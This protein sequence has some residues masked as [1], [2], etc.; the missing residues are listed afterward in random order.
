[1][2]VWIMKICFFLCSISTMVNGSTFLEFYNKITF[3]LKACVV[4]IISCVWTMEQLK[5]K[6]KKGY[7]SPE[8]SLKYVKSHHL[9]RYTVYMTKQ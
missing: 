1:M 7:L 8:L 5:K 3:I 9:P 4:L 2:I 6:K